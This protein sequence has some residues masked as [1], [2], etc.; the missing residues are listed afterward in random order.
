MLII[1]GLR[2]WISWRTLRGVK[3]ETAGL[4]KLVGR[5]LRLV[6]PAPRRWLLRH[7]EAL[8]FLIVGG[9]FER[10]AGHRVWH[11]TQADYDMVGD[12]GGHANVLLLLNE[13]ITTSASGT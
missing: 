7:R 10:M 11:P 3:N 12:W 6:P 4:A 9:T 13:L 2:K 8:K 5:V 1:P